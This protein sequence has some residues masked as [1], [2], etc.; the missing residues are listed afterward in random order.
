MDYP[1]SHTSQLSGKAKRLNHKFMEK[2]RALIY[3]SDVNKELWEKAARIATY[4]LNGNPSIVLQTKDQF[5][6]GQE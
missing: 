5:R 2:A 1:I 4:L 3:N 6:S